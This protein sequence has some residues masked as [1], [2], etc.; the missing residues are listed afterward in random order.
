MADWQDPN[1]RL[2]RMVLRRLAEQPGMSTK[3]KAQTTAAEARRELGIDSDE[4][5]QAII[6]VLNV[7]ESQPA[8][9]IA[10]PLNGGDQRRGGGQADPPDAAAP[11]KTEIGNAGAFFDQAF[12]QLQRAYF[13]SLLMS[14]TM[15]LVGLAFLGLAAWQAIQHPDKVGTASV[16]GGIGVVQIVAL[17]YRNPLADIARA[18]AVAQQAKIAITSYLLG[19]SLV[20]NSIGLHETPGEQHLKS[21]LGLTDQAMRHLQACAG[22][23]VRDADE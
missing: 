4:A 17:F 23:P 11:K 7:V 10:P 22:V 12:R 21:L 18:V 1:Y 14:G 20:H 16:V 2:L 6:N 5:Y 9:S 13:V 3:L 8:P 19:V 15:F